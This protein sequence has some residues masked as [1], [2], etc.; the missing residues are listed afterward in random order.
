MGP[1]TF[2]PHKEKGQGVDKACN[3]DAAHEFYS[4]KF[5]TFYI[6]LHILRS[7]VPSLSNNNHI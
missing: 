7:L 6:L 4:Y 2:I 5:D 3:G 1:I